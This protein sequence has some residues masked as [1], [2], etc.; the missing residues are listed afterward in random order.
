[1]AGEINYFRKRFFGGFNREDVV[2][3]IAKLARERNEF[4]AAKDKA[5]QDARVLAGEVAALRNELEETRQ[6]MVKYKAETLEAAIRAITELEYSFGSLRGEIVMATKKIF[7]EISVAQDIITSA[8]SVLDRAA[9]RCAELRTTLASGRANADSSDTGVCGDPET[10]AAAGEPEPEAVGELE[11]EVAGERESEIVSEPEPEAVGEP[12][13]EAAGERESEIV[14]EPE[15]EAVGQLESEVVGEPESEAVD[16][17]ELETVSEPESGIVGEPEPEAVGES[18]L[19]TAGEPGSEIVN[20]PEPEA[21]GEP[22]LEAAG[23]P[24]SEI[25]GEPE[26]EPDL[27]FESDAAEEPDFEA[28][29][30]PEPAMKAVDETRSVSEAGFDITTVEDIIGEI[31]ELREGIAGDT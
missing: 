10:E 15:P 13:L 29:G 9:E 12:E 31:V 4:S 8:P 5:V 14:S 20:E 17:S 21:V 11:S 18:E 7:A 1:M 25:V 19:E 26:P 27:E 6:A 2:E 22:E 24:E 16:E 28:S 23:E 3:Y 30:E